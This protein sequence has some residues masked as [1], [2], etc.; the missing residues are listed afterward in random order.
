MRSSALVLAGAVVHVGGLAFDVQDSV[1]GGAM[2]FGIG[3]F[4][5]CFGWTHEPDQR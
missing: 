5:M 3:L 2:M 4:G 1:I